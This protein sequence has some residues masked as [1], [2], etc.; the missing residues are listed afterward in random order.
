MQQYPDAVLKVWAIEW[1]KH[2]HNNF[3]TAGA[4]KW[5]PKFIDDGRAILT[6]KS[7]LLKSST[8]VEADLVNKSLIA[9]SGVDYSQVHQE[10]ATIPVTDKMRKYFWAKFKETKNVKWKY[11]ALMKK[12]FVTIPA[13]PFITVTDSLM[14]TFTKAAEELLKIYTR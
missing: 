9:G 12:K 5:E 10:G 1:E 3:E 8:T 13:R 6:G 14:N 11:L 4:G 7:G 2:I